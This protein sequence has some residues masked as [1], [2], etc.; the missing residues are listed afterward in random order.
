VLFLVKDRDGLAP[1][2]LL[3]VVD[4]AEIEDLALGHGAGVQ[5]AGLDDAPVAVAL[6]VLLP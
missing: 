3:A 6:A 1:S 5:S 2:G 4:L